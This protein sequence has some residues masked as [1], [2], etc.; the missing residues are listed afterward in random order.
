LQPPSRRQADALPSVRV[1]WCQRRRYRLP[2][3]RAGIVCDTDSI[4]RVSF[5]ATLK[6]RPEVINKTYASVAMKR[7]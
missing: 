3:T 4:P 5:V 2:E 7:R 6:P 1:A